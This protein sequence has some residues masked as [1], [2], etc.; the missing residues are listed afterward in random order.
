LE[1]LI[2]K[3][4]ILDVPK[5]ERVATLLSKLVSFE[6]PSRLV[7][8]LQP[9]LQSA[10]LFIPP[11]VFA[12]FLFAAVFLPVIPV[13]FLLGQPNQILLAF[14]LA[15]MGLVQSSPLLILYGRVAQR[16]RA[17][18]AELPFFA[19][20]LFILSHESFAN[21]P[22]SFRKVEQLGPGV[23]PAFLLEAQNLGRNLAYDGGPELSTIEKT[24]AG[25]PSS[26]L[27]D[28]IHGY[29]TTLQ[30]GRDV[31]EFVRGESE[32]LLNVHE[33]RWRSF[34]NSLSSITEVSFIFLSIFPMGIQMVAGTFGGGA[35]SLL[36]TT[37]IALSLAA[38]GLLLWLDRSQPLSYDSPGPTYALA[39]L[40]S[41][42]LV[43]LGL[44]YMGILRPV[45]AAIAIFSLS[46]A[47]SLGLRGFFGQLKG[48]EREVAAILH[49]LAEL[50]RAGVELPHAL[51]RVVEGIERFPSLRE[52]LL[53][54][55]RLLSLGHSPVAAQKSVSHP[56]W[57]VRI[58]FALLAVAF[59][60]GSG[61]EQLDRLSLSFAKLSD[62]K[63]SMQGALLPFAVLGVSVPLLSAASFW[64]LGSM[65]AL[66]PG[67]PFFSLGGNIR[68]AAESILACALL[69]GLLISK[70]YTLSVRAAV[71]LPPLLASAF[72]SFLIFPGSSVI[73]S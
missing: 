9:S 69:T 20:L 45:L 19:M 27:R 54:F 24:F 53:T 64:F 50:T 43:V 66:S 40:L 60:T 34:S 5:T 58:I 10:L 13:F 59:E 14:G 32:R 67:L 15:G 33:D 7:S 6:P 38:V 3:A 31:H 11:S 65:Q 12:R 63:R 1:P 21:L 51:S 49:D 22:D 41:A 30:T 56:S 37:V 26:R 36:E 62:A 44:S 2:S 70:A 28:L 23:L 42:A 61:Y 4:R 8:L 35:S 48:A 73:G 52:P 46:V 29:L 16:R 57:M 47:Y 39:G 55:S 17:I 71:G 68:G 25:H 72:I 18:E